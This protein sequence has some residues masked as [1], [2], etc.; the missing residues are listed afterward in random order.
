MLISFNKT[1][2]TNYTGR[3]GLGFTNQVVTGIDAISVK[4]QRNQANA[5]SG[6]LG[7]D[8][9]SDY[10]NYALGFKYFRIIY[11]EPQLN[12][13][14]AL[15]GIYFNHQEDKDSDDQS[16]GYQVEASFGT[17]FSFQG[18]ESIGF[19]FEFGIGVNRRNDYSRISSVGHNI[20]TSAIHFY[21]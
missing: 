6:I 12:F 10:S 20:L 2:A 16:D 1:Y 5:F 17:E 7:F 21:L 3:L 8:S 4:L 14:S 18:L 11:D 15:T 13:Y 9:T 19:S